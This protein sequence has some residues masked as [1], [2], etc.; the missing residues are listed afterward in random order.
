MFN[1]VFCAALYLFEPFATTLHANPNGR[2]T[3]GWYVTGGQ[4]VTMALV[5]DLM[6]INLGVDLIRP[7]D[8][9]RRAVAKKAKTQEMMNELYS[10]PAEITLSFRMQLMIKVRARTRRMTSASREHSNHRFGR[11][12]PSRLAVPMG[13]TCS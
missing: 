9:I 3:Q 11:S 10:V 2:F 8:L 12:S 4:V 1:V 5:G 7:G 13:A 6:V